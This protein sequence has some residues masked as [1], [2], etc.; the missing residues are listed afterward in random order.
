MNDDAARD[1]TDNHGDA[2][3][4]LTLA[5][6]CWAAGLA[7]RRPARGARFIRLETLISQSCARCSTVAQSS[8][9]GAT[10]G[11]RIFLQ[12]IERE[13]QPAA[14]VD[15]SK[16]ELMRPFSPALSSDGRRRGQGCVETTANG[17]GG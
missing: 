1:T 15:A 4:G 6:C 14:C 5:G 11:Q 2:R 17:A 9:A 10:T 12:M 13:R 7:S 8:G 16:K 3:T